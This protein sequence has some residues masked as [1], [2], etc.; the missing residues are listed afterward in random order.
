MAE[1][2]AD[3]TDRVIVAIDAELAKRGLGLVISYGMGPSDDPA[4]DP[5]VAVP[6]VACEITERDQTA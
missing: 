3:L 4:A 5:D 1:F 6:F 2:P